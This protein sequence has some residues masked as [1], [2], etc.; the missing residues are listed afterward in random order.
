MYNSGYR[1]I[2]VF[3]I[4]VKNH[5]F[6]RDVVRKKCSALNISQRYIASFKTFLLNHKYQNMRSVGTAVSATPELLHFLLCSD[7]TSF[8]VSWSS[9]CMR[10][11][12]SNSR[13]L[14]TS[15]LNTWKEQTSDIVG[16]IKKVQT[17]YLPA[18][19]VKAK[20]GL[21]KETINNVIYDFVLTA[22]AS[23][24]NTD[25]LKL[26]LLSNTKY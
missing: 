1:C 3:T 6:H 16:R 14:L 25:Y 17:V 9:S 24:V 23:F 13:K 19:T 15:D 8:R 2:L 11:I 5:T 26:Q 7:V 18:Q 4:V 22:C 21:F 10:N 20:S 12:A